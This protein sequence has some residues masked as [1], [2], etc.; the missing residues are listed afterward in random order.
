MRFILLC[1]AAVIFVSPLMLMLPH[2]ADTL[3]LMLLFLHICC[4]YSFVDAI[5][6]FYLFRFMPCFLIISM[7]QRD[8]LRHIFFHVFAM[9]IEHT[10]PCRF[11][12]SLLMPL[13]FIF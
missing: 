5:T 4:R 2:F 12:I 3:S 10:M 13:L 7:F 9:L 1:C 8:I 11:M 6:L